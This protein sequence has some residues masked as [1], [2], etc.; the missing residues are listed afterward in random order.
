VNPGNRDDGAR[1]GRGISFPPRIGA[2]GRVAWSAGPEN[3]R[4]AIRVIL[5]TELE[6][7]LMLPQLGGGLKRYLFQ[8]NTVSTHR[9]IQRTITQAL[10]RWEPRI[11]VESVEVELDAEDPQAALATLRYRLVATQAADQLT[12]RVRFTT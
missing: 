12:L 5:L 8:P 2:D 10:G 1:F 4:E 6:E 7:R 9:L 3:I 11:S